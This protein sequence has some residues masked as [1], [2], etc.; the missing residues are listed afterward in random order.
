MTVYGRKRDHFV[1]HLFYRS[2]VILTQGACS[3]GKRTAS[4]SCIPGYEGVRVCGGGLVVLASGEKIFE[5][6]N[7][8]HSR[9][10]FV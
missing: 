8:E 9:T 3:I 7:N 1:G 5:R 4:K 2:G 6:E 10:F